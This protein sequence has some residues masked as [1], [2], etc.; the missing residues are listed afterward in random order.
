MTKRKI[1][2]TIG[3]S[4]IGL[5]SVGAYVGFSLLTA[6]WY[7]LACIA[8]IAVITGIVYLISWLFEE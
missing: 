3:Y 7:P 2:R 6:W 1:K 4:L 8:A 5:L